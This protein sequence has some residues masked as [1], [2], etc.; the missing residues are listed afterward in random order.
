MERLYIV[1]GANGHLGTALLKLLDKN[2]SKVRALILQNDII[3]EKYSKNIEFYYGDVTVKDTLNSI[4]SN[5]EMYETVVIHCAGIVS[6]ASKFDTNV[7]NVNVNG[8]K[9]IADLALENKVKRFIYI[10]SVHAFEELKKGKTI[11]EVKRFNPDKVVGLYAKTKAIASNYVLD[12]VNE[13]LD[14]IIIHPSGIFGPYDYG[15]SHSSQFLID[16][17]NGDLKVSL[18]G[19][20]DFV[21]VR[22]VAKGVLSAVDKGKKGECYILSNDFFKVNDLMNLIASF[23]NKKPIRYIF[24]MWIAKLTAPFS[25]IY[26]K[27]KKQPPLFTTYSL[28]TLTSNAKFSHKKATKTLNYAPRKMVDTLKDTIIFMKSIGKIKKNLVFTK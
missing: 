15:K 10:S 27:S 20:Y 5:I 23:T 1:T 26:Y 19:G 25:E 7:F 9:N 13:G 14:A 24:P 18:N 6:I 2:N 22:D 21:D 12:K 3:H 8:T 16:Y 11:K 17:A 4:F 28:Y